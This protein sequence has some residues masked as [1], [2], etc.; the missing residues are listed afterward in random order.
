M[1]E[2]RVDL[3]IATMGHN[4]QRDS[5]VRFIRPH[6][7]RSETIVVGPRALPVASMLD[8]PGQTVCV[9]IGNG[10]NA[11]L[12]AQ[13]ARLMLFDEAGVLPDRLKDGT[14]RLAAQDDSFF[15]NYFTDPDFAVAYFPKFGFAQVPWGMAVARHGS[16][17]LAR[18]RVTGGGGT[19]EKARGL[20][21]RGHRLGGEVFAARQSHD[22]RIELIL[23][24]RLEDAR[25][26]PREAVALRGRQ[27]G[28]GA[29]SA[30]Q[31][32]R[33]RLSPEAVHG[34]HGTQIDDGAAAVKRAA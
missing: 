34:F 19:K 1:A 14:C 30:R 6:Y 4:T 20:E 3:V 32:G 5:Q 24:H 8:L 29:E 16:A 27:I 9:T 21:R 26:Q 28:E 18:A 15:A 7:Y 17:E 12:V 33:R 11:Q 10:S 2:D 25:E 23:R 13:G 31:L 22:A